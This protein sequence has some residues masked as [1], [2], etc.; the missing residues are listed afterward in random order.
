MGY[1][2]LSGVSGLTSSTATT[3]K[4]KATN[5]G[6]EVT[7]N[8]KVTVNDPRPD[9]AEDSPKSTT[10]TAE[11]KRDVTGTITLK[12][13]DYSRSSKNTTLNWKLVKKTGGKVSVTIKPA[14][15]GMSAVATLKVSKGLSSKDIR[16]TPDSSD[17]IFHTTFTVSVTNKATKEASTAV[18]SVD[19]KAYDDSVS[20][21]PTYEALPAEKDALVSEKDALPEDEALEDDELLQGEGT[22]TYGDVRN[23]SALTQNELRMISEGGYIIAAILPEITADESGQYDLDA[24]SLDEAVPEGYELVWFAFPRNAE[25]SEDDAI[26]E[27]YDEAG[28][29]IFAVPEGKA[30]VPAPWLDKDVTYAPVIAVRAPLAGDAKDSLDDAEAGDTVTEKALEEAVAPVTEE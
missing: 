10:L 4:L 2:D 17:K 14:S 28:A 6:T 24:V 20:D 9:F 18:I 21:F 13:A 5:Y 15:D 27:F 25:D 23:E 30:V 29:E 3:V 19:A 11:E 8:V 7:G 26:C 16:N 12:L 22:V 1:L